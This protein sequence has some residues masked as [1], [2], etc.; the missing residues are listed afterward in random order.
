MKEV[1][2]SVENSLELCRLSSCENATLDTLGNCS[3]HLLDRMGRALK[4]IDAVNIKGRK[5][6]SVADCSNSISCRTIQAQGV[7]S[8][9]ESDIGNLC[10]TEFDNCLETFSTSDDLKE[11]QVLKLIAKTNE[12]YGKP[13]TWS[14]DLQKN[15]GILLFGLSI[16]DFSLMTL[17]DDELINKIGSVNLNNL[18]TNVEKFYSKIKEQRKLSTV[19]YEFLNNLGNLI[20]GMT[21][22]DIDAVS[23]DVFG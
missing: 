5:K 18:L 22:T 2:E 23:V 7:S 4:S 9:S 6:R 15:L 21:V 3:N 14:I 20:C 1:R 11:S 16:Q 8:L 12:F 10:K 19:S 13:S 17:T